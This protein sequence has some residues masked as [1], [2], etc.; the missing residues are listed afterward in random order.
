MKRIVIPIL[1]AAALLLT[2]S[3]EKDFEE[4]N[5][6]PN[7]PQEYLTYALFNGANYSLIYNLRRADNSAYK[8]RGWMQYTSLTTYTDES[9][10][11]AAQSDGEDL[12]FQLYKRINSYKEIIDINTDP[13]KKKMAANYGE[14]DNQIAAARIM[15]AYGFS[16]IA[17]TF[18]DAPYYS[19]GS[20]NNER[21]Q[22][23]Q[24]DKYI[25]PVY[26]T[27]K[28]IY[29]DILNELKEAVE[30]TIGEDSEVFSEGDFIFGSVG[31]MKRF[32]NSLRLRI[33]NHLKDVT[34]GELKNAALAVVNHYRAGNEGELL[35]ENEV[36][37]LKFENS[38]T[39]PGPIFYDYFANNRL[40]Y[41]PSNVFVK[42]LCGNNKKAND[43]G[44]INFHRDPRLTA[45]CAPI[46]VESK[47]DALSGSYPN[48]DIIANPTD[49]IHFKGMPY[50]MVKGTT[51]NQ[52]K[53][54]EG[55]SLFS[56]KLLEATS[57]EPFMTYAEVCFILSEIRGWNQTW[58]ENGVKASMKYWGVLDNSNDF[59]SNLPAASQETVLTQ[60]Y[61]ALFRDP[62]EAWTEYRRTGFPKFLIK[63]GERV[64]ANNTIEADA[65]SAVAE[66][67]IYRFIS[68]ESAIQ[69]IPDRI[70]Y[71]T[72][73]T[74]VNRENYEKALRNM[75]LT[76]DDDQTS[77]R[78]HKLI[79]A[80][81]RV[82]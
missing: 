31:K 82:D 30:M 72:S 24:I 74:G 19:Y 59:V 68:M 79:F 7:K 8:M 73:Y 22:A 57:P 52:F 53:G 43:R 65:D 71:P 28:E 37:E 21:F 26:A 11:R 18:G 76:P 13:K 51:S 15:M 44:T 75:G 12:W 27:Q 6:N 81:N 61:I 60:K 14:N 45:I 35:K 5:T 62:N 67:Y 29:L 58:Y 32:A 23:L 54:G 25:T 2:T 63:A 42:F 48:Y 55:I 9:R 20:R 38:Y 64:R 34:D 36:V 77:G 40:D 80:E 10:Y 47:W 33:A 78:T 41:T 46:G 1:C 66:N 50:G 4:I 69:R 39:F 16:L 17:E 56:K 70:S 49:T 3:C